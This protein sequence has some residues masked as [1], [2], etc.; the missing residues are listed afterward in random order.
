MPGYRMIQNEGNNKPM[1]SIVCQMEKAVATILQ[2][3]Y[4]NNSKAVYFVG[5]SAGGHLVTMLHKTDWRKYVQKRNTG[6]A[7]RN[8]VEKL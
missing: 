4:N 5:H 3:A 8:Q 1:E 6:E 2:E 7:L